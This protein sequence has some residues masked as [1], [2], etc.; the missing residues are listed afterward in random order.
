MRILLISNL[1]PSNRY[2]YYGTFVK[3]FEQGLIQN[4]MKVDKI[5]ITK[6]N[7][8]FSKLLSYLTFL[9]RVIFTCTF[10]K[11]RYDIIYIHYLNHTL[12]PFLFIKKKRL[13]PIILNAHGSD[14]FPEKKSSEY[15][16]KVAHKVISYAHSIVVPSQY[17]KN[18]VIRK[19]DFPQERVFI[20]PSSGI[21][22]SIMNPIEKE[23]NTE[24]I[25]IGYLG[26]IDIDKGWDT[27]ILALKPIKEQNLKFKLHI[28]G[29]GEQNKLLDELINETGLNNEFKRYGSIPHTEIKVFF[30]KIDLLIFPSRRRGESLGLVAI[31]A[32]ACGVPVIANK[33]GAVTDFIKDG[34]NGY[35]Y[36]ND[37]QLELTELIR[38]FY[39]LSKK[40]RIKMSQNAIESVKK[41]DSQLVHSEMAIFLTDIIKSSN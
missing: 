25:N 12:I 32:L 7:N 37:N 28:G 2:P 16:I 9:F 14:I 27:M 39:S 15:L 31:E 11:K 41:Y 10:L 24:Y 20:S 40:E 34:F 5:I 33:N 35:I 29:S 8:S 30:G 23:I 1:Y 21:D 38:K 19:F 17:F 36:N 4:H 3:N 6:K 26:R 18:E 13:P 22:S